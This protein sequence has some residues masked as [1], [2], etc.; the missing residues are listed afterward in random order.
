[1]SF[2][3]LRSRSRGSRRGEQRHDST[4]RGNRHGRRGPA[5][6]FRPL[7]DTLEARALLSGVE[8]VTNTT[9][10]GPGSLRNAINNATSGEIINFARSAFGTITLTSGPLVVASSLTIDGPG[11]K[12]VTINGNK[13]VE[14][15]LVDANVT[16]TV[17]GL[18]IT[19]GSAAV[20]Y[21]FGGDGGGGINNAGTLAVASCVITGNSTN[22]SGGG[23]LNN[24]NLTV[25][26]SVVS[27]NAAQLGGGI[28]NNA[29]GIV[30]VSGSTI[31]NNSAVNQPAHYYYGS[32]GGIN[33]L[34]TITIARSV[35]SGN[36]ANAGGG[37]A[38]D[39]LGGYGVI[40]PAAV[41]ITSSSIIDNTSVSG[42]GINT[43]GGT[44]TIS[45]STFASNSVGSATT[46]FA[47]GG[48]IYGVFD[49]GL[50]INISGSLFTNN[51]ATASVAQ[52]P[53]SAFGGAIYAINF[54]LG[55]GE[56]ELNISNS[57]FVQNSVIGSGGFGG[58]IDAESGI[59]ATVTGTSFTG[60]TA[61]A[62][63][64]AEGGAV[65]LEPFNNADITTLTN[66]AFQG[67]SAVIPAT[68]TIPEDEGTAFGGAL[69]NTGDGGSLT[70]SE[71]TFIGNQAVGG[72]IGGGGL[73]GAILL[74]NSGFSFTFALSNSLLMDNEATCL[75]GGFGASGGGLAILSSVATV[76]QT[77]FIGNQ[78]KGDL[79]SG[80][81]NQAGDGQG[82]AISN[83]GRLTLSDCTIAANAAI[84]G[85]GIDGAT[86]GPGQGGGIF[87]RG[88]LQVTNSTITGNTA[89]GG[90]GGGD[91]SGGGFFNYGN[92]YGAGTATFVDTLITLNQANGGSGGGQGV[93]GGL[94]IESG[95][96]TLTGKTKVVLNFASTSNNNIYGSYST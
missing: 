22:G 3:G 11:S 28:A 91:G 35:V 2:F 81:G 36:S 6:R 4:A 94:Y 16:A 7:I 89:I 49:L 55:V 13:T 52:N 93:G 57:A 29:T 27:D 46:S 24:G 8:T 41:T 47:L 64:A 67:N 87:N 19:G 54:G 86:G 10:S 90:A 59:A 72:P 80:A 5:I 42:G 76:S 51:T 1:M 43:F 26:S 48:A 70:V 32:G 62:I 69:S 33:N 71:T 92:A 82:G 34:G 45:G 68:P 61:T 66:C 23:I 60:N 58:A 17:S 30:Q 15:L 18:T 78:A 95:T 40:T 56:G 65:S 63:A 75:P 96:I 74:Q 20:T 38:N 9:D 50:N 12:N 14:D 73:G 79:G 77:S 53:D 88:L 21:A 39:D 25:T 83:D 31:T 44:L 84:G 37:I 85:A